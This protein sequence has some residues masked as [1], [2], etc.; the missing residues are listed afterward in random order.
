MENPLISHAL[1][2]KWWNLGKLQLPDN[3]TELFLQLCIDVKK[4]NPY[5]LV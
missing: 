5:W 2:L 3:N 1:F 4:K